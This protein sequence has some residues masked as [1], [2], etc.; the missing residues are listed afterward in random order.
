[1]GTSVHDAIIRQL[2]HYAYHIGQI[3]FVAKSIR[4]DEFESLSIPKGA[5]QTY[6]SKRFDKEKSIKHF[7]EDQDNE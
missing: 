4:G 6:N 7:T 1:M 2:C 5:S 3:V